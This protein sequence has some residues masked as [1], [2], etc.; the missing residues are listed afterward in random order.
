MNRLTQEWGKGSQTM[1]NPSPRSKVFS[2]SDD[3]SAEH[4]RKLEALFGNGSNTSNG[5]NGNNEGSSPSPTND[6]SR[7]RVSENKVFS[8]PRKSVGRTPSEYRM[9]LERLR[10]AREVEEIKE[11]ADGFMQYHQLPDD[12]DILYKVLQ[13][14]SEK[15][16][17]E[18]LGQISSLISQ[19]RINGSM[20]LEDR[21]C[22]LAE[23]ATENATRS[24][25]EGIR[26]Q[27]E[28]IK[29]T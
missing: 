24:Y 25:I 21:L 2:N 5:G 4:R 23:R 22:S 18:A 20:I 6:A 15:V 12:V 3:S 1:T 19:G 8:S 26:G 10:I 11:A 28:R 13:H 17:R 7:M 27:L 29:K 9:R 14:P 16:V